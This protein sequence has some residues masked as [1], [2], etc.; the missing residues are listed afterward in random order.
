MHAFYSDVHVDGMTKNVNH[1][2]FVVQI[3]HDQTSYRHISFF[4][5]AKT[6]TLQKQFEFPIVPKCDNDDIRKRSIPFFI[7]YFHFN[8]N[9]LNPLF[10]IGMLT[11]LFISSFA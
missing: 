7:R 2:Q 8:L 9:I 6:V 4:I 5:H 3:E 1:Q 10:C 11:F